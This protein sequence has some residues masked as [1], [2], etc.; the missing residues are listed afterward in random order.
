MVKFIKKIFD[1]VRAKIKTALFNLFYNE[2]IF[3]II[4]EYLLTVIKQTCSIMFKHLVIKKDF[5]DYLQNLKKNYIM[6]NRL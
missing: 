4:F 1:K 6:I 2:F 3:E 5:F